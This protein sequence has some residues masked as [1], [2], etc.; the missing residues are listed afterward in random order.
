MA[1]TLRTSKQRMYST[2]W[3]VQSNLESI[4]S[5]EIDISGQDV[6]NIVKFSGQIEDKIIDADSIINGNLKRQYTTPGDFYVSSWASLPVADKDNTSTTPRLISVYANNNATTSIDPYTAT[7]TIDITDT[8]STVSLY[9]Y[10]LKSSLEGSQGTG[11]FTS[12]DTTSTNGDVTILAAAWEN[13]SSLTVGDSFYFSIVD[14][15]P[16]I[17][18]LSKT[19]ASSLALESIFTEEAPNESSASRVM[20]NKAISVLNK[21]KDPKGPDGMQLGKFTE[22]SGKSLLVSYKVTNLGEDNSPYLE[23][24]TDAEEGYY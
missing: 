4:A 7:W 12:T 16:L 17:N 23:T 3:D 8:T 11:L 19:I 2:Y 9:K 15:D 21:L 20:W 14:V 22:Y 13:T 1:A 6:L 24:S 5:E 10:S 18:Y